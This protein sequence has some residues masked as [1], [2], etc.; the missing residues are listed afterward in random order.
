MSDATLSTLSASTATSRTRAKQS[1]SRST[2]TSTRTPIPF[3]VNDIASLA[4]SLRASIEQNAAPSH[5]Q[6]LNWL[7]KA[8][9]YQ[10]FQSLRT[11]A[12]ALA[13]RSAS[14]PAV[15]EKNEPPLSLSAHTAKA[16]T[17]FDELGRLHKWPHK[18]TVQRIAMWGLWF[19]FDAKK[20]Y[21]EK[22]VNAVLKA[23]HTF[24][25]HATLRR[26]LVNMQ[27]L[28][29]ESDCSVYWKVAQRPNDEVR[30][31]L[32]ALRA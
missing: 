17:Q 7:A 6:M 12:E 21:T 23:W 9:G 31:F 24:G 10:N 16:L 32:R 14:A 15:R 5:V 11:S 1:S 4:K 27:L 30:A 20:R 22:D 3:S 18:F 13:S 2:K 26:E 28:A 8:A 29:R 25:D 19:R